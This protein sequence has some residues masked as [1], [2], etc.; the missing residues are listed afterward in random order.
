M[1]LR[2]ALLTGSKFLFLSYDSG[3]GNSHAE[4]SIPCYQVERLNNLMVRMFSSEL[5]GQH[6]QALPGDIIRTVG[7]KK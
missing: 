6:I 7:K 2:C 4:P 3:V 1:S 5:T